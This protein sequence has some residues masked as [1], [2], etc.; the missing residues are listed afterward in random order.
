MRYLF[1]ESNPKPSV[2]LM[3]ALRSQHCTASPGPFYCERPRVRMGWVWSNQLNFNQL[4]ISLDLSS[5]LVKNMLN[6]C[7]TRFSEFPFL[8]LL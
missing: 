6:R 1:R 7:P 2:L 8:P 5:A 3:G 4:E